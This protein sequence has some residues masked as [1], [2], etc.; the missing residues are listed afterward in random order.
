MRGS[1]RPAVHTVPLPHQGSPIEK[2]LPSGFVPG[3]PWTPTV[4]KR[5][6]NPNKKK[7]RLVYFPLP[8]FLFFF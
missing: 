8:F 4:G 3:P 7:P 1:K 5:G 6:P 2:K